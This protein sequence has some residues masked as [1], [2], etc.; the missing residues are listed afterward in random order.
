L[1]ALFPYDGR[2]GLALRR[3][4][5]LLGWASEA[6]LPV[7]VVGRPFT[8]VETV[9]YVY[10]LPVTG[11]ET[12]TTITVPRGL[13]SR[14]VEEMSGDVNVW[15]EGLHMGGGAM[16]VFRFTI[17]TEVAV[18]QVDE[19]V[20][21]LEGS[22]YGSSPSGAPAVSLWNRERDEWERLDVGWGRHV[23]PDAGAFLLE[24]GEVLLR[25]ETDDEWPA[26]VSE[27]EITLRGRR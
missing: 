4:V 10:A 8:T 18:E 19:L 6:P 26:E 22:S 23:I 12:G 17:W 9:L 7:E 11:L 3:G 21:T 20:L 15:P 16:A 1:Q 13:I 14:K 25:L 24:P 2:H 27:L 5:Y